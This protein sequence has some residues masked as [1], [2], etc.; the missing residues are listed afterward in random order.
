[1][2]EYVR[3][4]IRGCLRHLACLE[5]ESEELDAEILR[6]MQSPKSALVRV[7]AGGSPQ[8]LSLPR[9]TTTPGWAMEWERSNCTQSTKNTIIKTQVAKYNHGR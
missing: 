3:F 9:S 5:E 6:R 1:M 7:C 8:R 4:L 2:C